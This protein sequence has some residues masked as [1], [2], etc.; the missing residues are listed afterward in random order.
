M[1]NMTMQEYLTAN[2]LDEG[3]VISIIDGPQPMLITTDSRLAKQWLW[4]AMQKRE[5]ESEH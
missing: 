4:K 3:E 5:G 2:D 1:R